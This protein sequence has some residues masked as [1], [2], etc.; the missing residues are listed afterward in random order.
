MSGY[1][2]TAEQVETWMDARGLDR[3]DPENLLAL[4]AHMVTLIETVGEPL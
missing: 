1:D 4:A 2:M 3:N